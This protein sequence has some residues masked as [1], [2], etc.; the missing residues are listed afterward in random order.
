MHE[1]MTL[2][3]CVTQDRLTANQHSVGQ[4]QNLDVS[5]AIYRN[6]KINFKP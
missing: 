4:L 6:P 1:V 5:N 3:C 2:A